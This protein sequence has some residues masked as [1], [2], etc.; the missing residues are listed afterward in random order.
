[1]EEEEEENMKKGKEEER[2]KKKI[3][4][5]FFQTIKAKSEHTIDITTSYLLSLQ[6]QVSLEFRSLLLSPPQLPLILVF[7]LQN[8]LISVFFCLSK[9]LFCFFLSL[10]VLICYL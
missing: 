5:Q 10:L 1:M 4:I 2:K 7:E 8:L 6:S 3:N 9:H